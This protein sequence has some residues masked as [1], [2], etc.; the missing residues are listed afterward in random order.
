M[1]VDG[2][3]VEIRILPVRGRRPLEGDQLKDFEVLVDDH[4]DAIVQK[5]IE[6]FVLGRPV[7]AEVI[8]RRI[9]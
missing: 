7:R 4:A 1:L 9:R 5:W 8:T 2:R 3:V 6:Y